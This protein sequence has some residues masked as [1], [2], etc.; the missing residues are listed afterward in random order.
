MRWQSAA[1][2]LSTGALGVSAG[3]GTPNVGLQERHVPRSTG[4]RGVPFDKWTRDGPIVK[5][6][7]NKNT[8]REFAPGSIAL[9][10]EYQTDCSTEFAVNGSGI[11]EVD[12]DIGEAYAGRLSISDDL[13]DEN[14]LFFWFQPS[15]NPAAEKEIVIWLN[16]GVSDRCMARVVALSLTRD[17]SLVA[18]LLRASYRKMARSC[19]NTALTSRWLIRGV[20]IT[21]PT[22]SGSSSRLALAFLPAR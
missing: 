13:D 11:P 9:L 20:G 5:R 6:F 18:R 3:R 19:G 16:G 21:F 15:P 22:W 7:D 10:L 17:S 4:S 8:T 14:K 12:F 2:L 1:L